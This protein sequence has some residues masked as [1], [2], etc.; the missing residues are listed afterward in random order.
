M[1]VED[2]SGITL[3]G[4]EPSSRPLMPLTKNQ[5]SFET[6]KAARLRDVTYP[7]F[8]KFKKALENYEREVAEKN[9]EPGLNIQLAS[10]D[11]SVDHNIL[12]LFIER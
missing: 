5:S 8:S 2:Q 11:S 12:E 1:S 7:D 3:G 10:Y 4:D 9:K 6:I